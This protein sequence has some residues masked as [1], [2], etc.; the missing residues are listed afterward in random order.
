MKIQ[1]RFRSNGKV[2]GEKEVITGKISGQRIYKGGL[3]CPEIFGEDGDEFGY[4]K[5]PYPV[6]HPLAVTGLGRILGINNKIKKI[7][8]DGHPFDLEY[9]SGPLVDKEGNRFRFVFEGDKRGYDFYKVVRSIDFDELKNRLSDDRWVVG[10]ARWG[11]LLSLFL[12]VIPVIPPKYRP[13]VVSSDDKV[14]LHSLNE[15]Y[16][17]ILK[18]IDRIQ[19]MKQFPKI[20]LLENENYIALSRA[21][22]QLF[23]GGGS[24]FG[25]KLKSII[26]CL[27]GKGGLLR[28][29]L[30]GKRSDFSGRS[31]ITSGPSLNIDQIGIPLKMG[32]ELFEPFCINQLVR[33]GYSYREAFRIYRSDLDKAREVLEKVVVDKKVL[34][35]RQPTL[36]RFGIQA[37]RPIIHDGNEIRF[38]PL[39]CSPFNADFDG[40]SVAVHLPVSREAQR[41]VS[42]MLP[43]RNIFGFGSYDRPL[44]V[45]THEMIVGA[46]IMTNLK[47][48]KENPLRFKS[49]ESV[50]TAYE[51]GVIKLNELILVKRDDGYDETCYGRLLLERLLKVRIDFPIDKKKMGEL[52]SRTNAEVLDKIKE[53]TFDVVTKH[54]LSLGVDELITPSNKK[55]LIE[56]CQEFEKEVS[57]NGSHEMVVRKW[58]DAFKRMDEKFLSESDEDSNIMLMYKSGSRVNMAQIRQMAIAKGLV[59][60]VKN[61]IIGPIVHSFREGLDPVEYFVSCHSARK[62]MTDKKFVTPKAGYLAR[63]LVQA[64]RDLYCVE[65]DCHSIEGL[66]VNKKYAIGRYTVDG[67]LITK[68]NFDEFP[69]FVKIRSPIFC[70]SDK[71]ICK[72][73]YGFDHNRGY[74]VRK[75]TAVGVI[76]AQTL[77]EPTTQLTMRT[78]HL[79]GVAS[80]GSRLIVRSAVEGECKIEVV[81]VAYYKVSIGGKN[82]FVDTFA[83]LMVKDGDYVNVGDIICIYE[84][85]ENLQDDIVNKLEKLEKYFDLKVSTSAAVS[86]GDCKVKV[87]CMGEYVEIVTHNGEVVLKNK[88]RGIP[89]YVY[90]GMNVKK[91]Q[92]L[93]YGEADIKRMFSR[94]GDLSLIGQVFVNRVMELYDGLVEVSVHVEV[95]LRGFSDFVLKEDGSL[96]LR[97]FGDKGPIVLKGSS[98]TKDNPSWLKAIGY[99]WAKSR[100][101]KAAWFQETSYDLPSERI[102]TGEKIWER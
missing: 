29:N 27:V 19:R 99:G 10:L 95:V 45:P 86:I 69:D 3:F 74:L 66:V 70:E 37:F 9:G 20:S 82:Y 91:G 4:I 52:I 38:P 11:D 24:A 73:C 17:R 59:V 13:M 56:E 84:N 87:R 8:Y 5:L 80:L 61:Q 40:D 14:F 33:E 25:K 85:E 78:K 65:D 32:L 88:V 67:K 60:D 79:G 23:V 90:D 83:R 55:E 46:F 21:V 26:D 35:N 15:L 16:S 81:S 7:V 28:G 31:V 63:R 71:G 44:I 97:S 43:S 6:L 22:Y 48:M 42:R 18:V 49:F 47:R 12:T 94:T 89:I 72:I 64:C 96:G 39:C 41:E 36:H 1:V 93:T 51:H 101:E 92:F 2:N 77:S 102:M 98:L 68:S 34:V 62:S 75:G 58:S 30:L 100:L 53:I 76:A 54:G 50:E 57:D